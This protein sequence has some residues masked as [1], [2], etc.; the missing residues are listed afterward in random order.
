MAERWNNRALFHLLWPLVVEQVLAVTIGTVDTM[1]MSSVGEY[2]VSGVSLVDAIAT[3]LIITF[4]ALATGGA[5]VISQ[6]IGRR[7]MTNASLASKQL[8]YISVLAACSIMVFTLLSRRSL[9]RLIYGNIGSDVMGA[10]E[11]Y[12]W[13][14]ALGYPFLS[15]YNAS[16][17]LFRS[18]GNS[19]IT[20]MVS[21]LVN[22][23]HVGVN[24]IL[25]YGLGLGVAGAALSTLT[26]RIVAA[27][28]LTGLLL[29][30]RVGPLSLSGLFKIRIAPYIIRSILK[31][32]VP[33]GL[34]SSMFQLGKLLV[35]R[36][37]TTFGTAAIA[38]NAVTGVIISFANMPAGAFGLAMITIVGQCIGAG[39]YS[40]A[41]RF[42]G[43]LMKMVHIIMFVISLL[44]LIF[45]DPIVGFFNLTEGSHEMTKTFLWV[46]CIM[47]PISWPPSWTLP[48]ALRAAGDARYVMILAALSMWA[49]RVL[50]AYLCAYTF[51]F[52]VIGVWYAMVADW[53]VRAVFYIHR[54]RRGRWQEKRII[55]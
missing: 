6:Y 19:R 22:L 4:G 14:S 35:S 44:T 42:T 52:G 26:S 54:W 8:I 40:A 41:R 48:N 53:C 17:A 29:S 13:I 33:S 30:R 9:L 55:P 20:M 27:L 1:M 12:F 34:E 21:V 39:D 37:A 7:D 32:G 15:L 5:V 28:L 50:G 24:F 10:A 43:R 45:L 11:T 18:M 23:L 16:A 38:A 25:I 49:V 3:L 31:V 2:A 51:G 47:A 46:L 36:I